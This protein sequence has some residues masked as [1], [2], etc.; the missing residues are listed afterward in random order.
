MYLMKCVKVV[1]PRGIAVSK[2]VHY[3][4]HILVKAMGEIGTVPTVLSARYSNLSSPVHPN[5]LFKKLKR[6]N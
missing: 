6:I 1:D 3:F 5:P 4:R 2:I